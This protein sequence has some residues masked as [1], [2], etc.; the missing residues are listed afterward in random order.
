MKKKHICKH[1]ELDLRGVDGDG[2]L[3]T[4]I[5]KNGMVFCG[6]FCFDQYLMSIGKAPYYNNYW[7]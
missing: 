3:E 4:F 7:L 6:E 1:C 5:S 2:R